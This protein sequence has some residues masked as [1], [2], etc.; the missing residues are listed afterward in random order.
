VIILLYAS[1]PLTFYRQTHQVER[2]EFERY[3]FRWSLATSALAGIKADVL[4]IFDCSDAAYLCS[5]HSITG[6]EAVR[7]EYLGPEGITPAP[8][9][10]SF[11]EAL[12]WA[13]LILRDE[14]SFSTNDLRS[15]I[16]Q[17]P[18]FARKSKIS[19][20]RPPSYRKD[21]IYLAPGYS[22]RVEL[23]QQ[24]ADYSNEIHA[25]RRRSSIQ[26]SENKDKQNAQEEGYLQNRGQPPTDSGYASLQYHE[27]GYTDN[28]ESL[29]FTH[30]T[31]EDQ[32][33][34]P[35]QRLS[36]S[37][38]ALEECSDDTRTVY[39]DA[40]SLPNSEKG[41]FITEMADELLSKVLSENPDNQT[42][43]RIS[44]ILPELLSA[45]ALKVGCNAESQMHLD[46]MVFIHK[47]RG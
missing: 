24:L 33:Q 23:Q 7:F 1:V 26:G 44:A 9:L 47:N 10:K 46:V 27:I 13:L 21:H 22:N 25:Q 28:P 32:P 19:L 20:R 36:E 34:Q 12:M 2:Q 45:F 38:Q 18:S 15:K 39:L 41:D 30:F 37:D 8:G 4:A 29:D 14:G 6:S 40:S 42:V 3:S 35:N 16:N 11:T 17:A 43:E 5:N 31:E